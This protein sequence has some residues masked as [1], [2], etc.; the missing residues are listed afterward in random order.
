MNY[1]AILR[2]TIDNSANEEG[3]L[4]CPRCHERERY[5][6]PWSGRTGPGEVELSDYCLTYLRRSVRR[7]LASRP[8]AR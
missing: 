4:C 8:V 5:A 2:A 6:D 3:T 1:M 7:R